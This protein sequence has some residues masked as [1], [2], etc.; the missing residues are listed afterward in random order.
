MATAANDTKAPRVET[1]PTSSVFLDWEDWD[2]A[3]PASPF[4]SAAAKPVTHGFHTTPRDTTPRRGSLMTR[5]GLVPCL[6]LPSRTT[7]QGIVGQF[8]IGRG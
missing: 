1:L 5:S 7:R 2:P 8:E 6:G 4:K 3:G